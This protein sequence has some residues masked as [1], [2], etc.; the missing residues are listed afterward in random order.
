MPT[1]LSMMMSAPIATA[2][3]DVTRQEASESKV[4]ASFQMVMDQ[5]TSSPSSEPEVVDLLIQDP[6]AEGELEVAMA[7]GEAA[8]IS[9]ATEDQPPVEIRAS[10]PEADPKTIAEAQIVKPASESAVIAADA[11]AA[12]DAAQNNRPIEA[13]Q[14]PEIEVQQ[15]IPPAF[16]SLVFEAAQTNRAAEAIRKPQN[17]MPGLTP[18]TKEIPVRSIDVGGGHDVAQ[19]PP[20]PSP[21]ARQPMPPD[22]TPS[23]TQMQLIAITKPT[24][25]AN[26]HPGPETEDVQVAK[27]ILASSTTR[28]SGLSVQAMTAATRAETTRAIA[29]QMANAINV[30]SHS[31]TIEVALNPEEL[32]RVSIVLNGRDDGLYMTITAER[33]ETLDMMRRHLS[34]LEMEFQNFGLGGLSIDLGTSADARGDEPDGNEDTQFLAPQSEHTP[35]AGPTPSR[36]SPDGRIDMRL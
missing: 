15:A 12:Q 26:A 3:T 1:P 14:D 13:L 19:E 8:D 10:M 5:E 17:V 23:V 27:E 7:D 25:E 30:R 11:E 35:E 33:P 4:A 21:A 2:K 31:G 24:D 29:S 34:V 6:D 22:Q 20:A 36:A 16:Q 9:A 18:Y 28:D 32:G